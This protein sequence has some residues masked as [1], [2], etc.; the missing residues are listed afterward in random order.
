MP[1]RAG[2]R[3]MHQGGDN[4]PKH[5]F[6]EVWRRGQSL[7]DEVERP[8]RAGGGSVIRAAIITVMLAFSVCFA[9]T[10]EK[11]VIYDT[12]MVI[13]SV[14]LAL[15]DNITIEVLEKSQKFYS[16]SFKD[17][18]TVVEIA[19][20]LISIFLVLFSYLNFKYV[21]KLKNANEKMKKQLEE[22]QKVFSEELGKHKED[23]KNEL[24]GTIKI[25]SEMERKFKKEIDISLKE[26]DIS[27][28]LLSRM[29]KGLAM[30]NLEKN[31]FH[32]YFFNMHIFYR[33]LIGVNLLKKNDLDRLNETHKPF[34][35]KYKSLTKKID[36]IKSEDVFRW[37]L[38]NLLEFIKHCDDNKQNDKYFFIA[39]HDTKIIYKDLCDKLNYNDIIRE[40]G[41][42]EDNPIEILK[43]A[44]YYYREK[45]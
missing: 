36:D 15:S 26:I 21:R 10:S 17:I 18:M 11:S 1:V 9:Q 30:E 32:E 20:A 35:E 39:A 33:C 28:R 44:E 23:M 45:F 14:H 37:F 7:G 13:D 29:H 40:L 22:Q 24:E 6:P 16:D 42:L 8:K 43:L 34:I 12:I 19:V 5:M 4:S 3:Y 41:K 25:T 38:E 2:R 27:L 31:D